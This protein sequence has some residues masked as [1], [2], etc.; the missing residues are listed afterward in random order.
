[1]LTV[2]AIEIPWRTYLPALLTETVGLGLA[3]VGGLLMAIRLLDMIIDP[4]IGWAPATGWPRPLDCDG[5]GWC[6]AC[7]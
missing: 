7:P 3:T 2:Q 4:V 6:S 1:M 5:P